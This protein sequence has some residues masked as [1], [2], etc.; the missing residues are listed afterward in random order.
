M[1]PYFLKS[2]NFGNNGISAILSTA[3]RNKFS[4]KTVIPI[5]NVYSEGVPFGGLDPPDINNLKRGKPKHE[6]DGF[7]EFHFI[8]PIR[9]RK[10]G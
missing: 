10:I 6:K 1:I 2:I 7:P 5:E 3:K 4:C 9:R 8:H